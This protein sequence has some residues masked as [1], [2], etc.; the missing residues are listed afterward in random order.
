MISRSLSIVTTVAIVAAAAPALG[1]PTVRARVAQVERRLDQWR[2]ADAER[3]LVPLLASHGRHPRVLQVHGE[4]LLHLGRYAEAYKVLKQA[5]RRNRTSA[6]LKALRDL[7]HSTAETTKRYVRNRSPG[8]HFE[9]WTSPGRDRLLATFAAETLEATRTAL[10]RDLGH[11]PA[12]TLRVEVLPVPEDLARVSPLTLDD[13][14]RTGTI[15]LCK[16]NRLMIVSPSALLRG[17]SWRDTLAHEY[18]HLVISQMSHNTV[19]IWLH[20][21]LAKFFE[22]R[23]RLPLGEVTPLTPTQEHLLSGALRRRKLIR[24]E[25][26]HP[27]MA[28]LPS[29]EATALA[30]AQ[31]QTAVQFLVEQVELSGLRRVITL[32]RSGRSV[33]EAIRLASGM[34]ARQF[35]A[36]WKQSLRARNLRQLADLVPP[37]LR[38]GKGSKERRLAAVRESRARRFLRLAELLRS[39]RLTRAAIIEYEKAR[40][41]LGVRNDLVAN[42][43]ARAYMEAASPTQ[44]ISALMPVLEYYPELPGPQVTMGLAYLRN[45]QHEQAEQHFEVALRIN[46]FNPELH[47]GMAAAIKGRNAARARLHAEL[48]AKLR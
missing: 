27:S 39:R 1:T 42:H 18:V 13:I 7:A 24:W 38:F 26:M 16:F 3:L 31:V 15:A 21:G 8:G 12:S 9:I 20:E 28:K 5:V 33:W 23:W 37:R 22:A 19:P 47:C 25:Q 41:I 2:V 40:R 4:L 32:V 11:V 17:Y 14:R 45:S 44:A 43:L 34:N 48:C 35:K 6:A 29:Q 46:P 10:E 36:R 30:F